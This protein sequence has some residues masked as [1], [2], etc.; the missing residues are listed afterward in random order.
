MS[1]SLQQIVSHQKIETSHRLSLFFILRPSP[2]FY[3]NAE[4]SCSLSFSLCRSLYLSPICV[5]VCMDL[6][7]SKCIQRELLKTYP[8]RF[9]HMYEMKI[10]CW[11]FA[12]MFQTLYEIRNSIQFNSIAHNRIKSNKSF[13]FEFWWWFFFYLMQCI[14]KITFKFKLFCLNSVSIS[15]IFS[16]SSFPFSFPFF[17]FYFIFRVKW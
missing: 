15:V 4:V 5:Y 9:W 2:F 17:L 1:V 3:T 12:S 8:M 11:S 13:E 7:R 14:K 16:H 10:L 6:G